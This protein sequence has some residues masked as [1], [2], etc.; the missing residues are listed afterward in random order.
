M[1]KRIPS[2]FQPPRRSTCARAATTT[3]W[4]FAAVEEL[5]AVPFLSQFVIAHYS[6]KRAV[7][8]AYHNGLAVL[9][10]IAIFQGIC[11]FG[12]GVDYLL[13]W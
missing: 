3:P 5:P 12:E 9:A 7:I 8:V 2:C 1:R 10:Q 4:P 11:E 6:L 13:F